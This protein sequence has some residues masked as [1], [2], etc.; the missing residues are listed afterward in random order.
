MDPLII[1][2]GVVLTSLASAVAAALAGGNCL[3]GLFFGP[4]G[5][6]IAAITGQGEKTRKHIEV[7]TDAIL[8]KL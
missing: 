1:I 7:A 3:W 6:V 8:K 5:I 2:V 4:L